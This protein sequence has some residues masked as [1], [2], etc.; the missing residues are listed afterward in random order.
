MLTDQFNT[1][2]NKN[3]INRLITEGG[4]GDE[5]YDISRH[6]NGEMDKVDKIKENLLAAENEMFKSQLQIIAEL[7]IGIGYRWFLYDDEYEVTNIHIYEGVNITSTPILKNG[8]VGKTNIRDQKFS[9][10]LVHVAQQYF[11]EQRDTILKA[12]V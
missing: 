12:I 7:G 11:P 5:V 4:E 1:L 6:L 8:K 3:L 9:T 2:E 10:Y